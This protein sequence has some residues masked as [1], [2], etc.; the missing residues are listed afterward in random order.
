MF[1][2]TVTIWHVLVYV[3]VV[4]YLL[5]YTNWSQTLKHVQVAF[6][7]LHGVLEVILGEDHFQTTKQRKDPNPSMT[8]NGQKPTSTT[9][10]IAMRESVLVTARVV[11]KIHSESDVRERGCLGLIVQGDTVHYGSRSMRRWTHCLCCQ[12]AEMDAGAQLLFSLLLCPGSQTIGCC[13]PL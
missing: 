6:G 5:L 9:V 8:D 13:H 3:T 12:K 7:L 10:G 2:L 11:I 4:H 1:N